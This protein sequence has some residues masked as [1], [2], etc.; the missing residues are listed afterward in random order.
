MLFLKALVH[1]MSDLIARYT[2][3][4]IHA[5]IMQTD[6]RV[7]MTITCVPT[8]DGS[9]VVLAVVATRINTGTR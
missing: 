5:A 4:D 9:V 7:S 6:A 8:P 1:K 2:A 3:R